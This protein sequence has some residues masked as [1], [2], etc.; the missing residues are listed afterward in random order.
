[1]AVRKRILKYLRENPKSTADE[2]AEGLRINY[3]TVTGA[4]SGL[5][6]K[7]EVEAADSW[8]RRFSV[9]EGEPEKRDYGIT[10]QDFM[11]YPIKLKREYDELKAE[12]N[13]LRGELNECRRKLARLAQRIVR[14]NIYGNN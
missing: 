2:I 5:K 4:L 9:A 11:E 3:K 12:N 13:R 1:M 7:G 10:V 6:Q 14:Q 8:P